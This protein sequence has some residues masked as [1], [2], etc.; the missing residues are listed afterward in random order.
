MNNNGA[1]LR[2]SLKLKE[3]L[4]AERLIKFGIVGVLVAMLY[5]LALWTMVELLTIPVL[6]ASSIA[7]ILVSVVNYILHH[8]W[9]FRSTNAHSSAFPRFALMN[10]A[11]FSINW[12]VMY[13][14]TEIF[15]I[16]YLLVQAVAIVFLVVWNFVLSHFWIFSN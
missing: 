3:V 12:I 6:M 7:F 9:T 11:G 5:Y 10:V 15:I 1:G 4:E 8:R 16:N 13:V 14:G 2:L